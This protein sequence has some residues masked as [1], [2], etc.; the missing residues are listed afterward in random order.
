MQRLRAA[1]SVFTPTELNWG[2]KSQRIQNWGEKKISYEQ[3]LWPHF[4][5]SH[6]PTLLLHLLYEALKV[7]FPICF[8]FFFVGLRF[9]L[10]YPDSKEGLQLTMTEVVK[11]QSSKSKKGYNQVKGG[12]IATNSTLQSRFKA[13]TQYNQSISHQEQ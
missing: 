11:K 10:L 6:T 8:V 3:P 9:S 13:T 4:N 1:G 5:S 12:F 7:H 2:H